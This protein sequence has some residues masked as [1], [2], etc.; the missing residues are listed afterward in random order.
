[1]MKEE[2]LALSCFGHVNSTRA[3]PWWRHGNHWWKHCFFVP[4][5]Q[6]VTPV[7]GQGQQRARELNRSIHRQVL[8]QF[9]PKSSL[10]QT[11]TQSFSFLSSLW[12]YYTF[13]G[14]RGRFLE[15]PFSGPAPSLVSSAETPEPREGEQ[16]LLGS[17]VKVRSRLW[18]FQSLLLS[19]DND[20]E[21]ARGPAVCIPVPA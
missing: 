1:M 7:A 20:G 15:V 4:E 3:G 2:C 19:K 8:C 6:A 11:A 14:G 16:N 12:L 5:S 10:H 21:T 18:F 9:G 17:C 13:G